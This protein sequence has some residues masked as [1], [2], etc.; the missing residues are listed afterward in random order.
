MNSLWLWIIF[1]L[2]VFAIARKA[3]PASDQ[4]GGQIIPPTEHQAITN[5]LVIAT[6]NIQTGKDEFGKRDISRSANLI[7][8]ADIVGLQEVYAESWLNKLGFGSCQTKMLAEPG[9]FGSLFCATRRRWFREHRGNAFLSKI[10]I[11]SWQIKML[12]DFTGKSYRNMT[13]VKLQWKSE[14]LTIINT[15]LHT[16]QGREQQLEI[17]LA[18]FNA[19]KRVILMGDLNSKIETPLL[20]EAVQNS[21]I[22]DAIALTKIDPDP[23]N[24]IDWILTKG[25][26][27]DS[28]K[29]KE[30]GISDHPYYEV[31]LI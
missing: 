27:V 25:C 11:D 15:H 21:D 17:V 2:T 10:P 6:Y 9:Q 13:I 22:T 12:P 29:F 28:G 3:K 4:K 19:H 23:I 8:N 14:P 30:K 31:T 1:A 20:K 18:E 26:K 16:R 5:Q 24:R 7:R